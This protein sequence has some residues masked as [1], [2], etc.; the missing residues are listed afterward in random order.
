[1]QKFQG[2]LLYIMNHS[3]YKILTI[4]I[5]IPQILVKLLAW[6]PARI[7]SFAFRTRR[8]DMNQSRC[9]T[10]QSEDLRWSDALDQ[11]AMSI[12]TS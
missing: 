5:L 6:D 10:E 2:I 7:Y 8:R 1:M 3:S 9:L 4:C 11:C 12:G